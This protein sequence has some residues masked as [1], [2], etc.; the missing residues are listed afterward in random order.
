MDLYTV[1]KDFAAPFAALCGAVAAAYF[2]R[3]QSNTAKRQADIALGLAETATRQAETALDQLRFN[4][5]EKRYAVYKEARHLL[6][7]MLA[8][9]SPS[10][11]RTL[12]RRFLTAI[13]EAKFFFPPTTCHWLETVWDDCQELLEKSAASPA[14]N[15]QDL[16]ALKDKLRDHLKEMSKHFDELNFRQFTRRDRAMR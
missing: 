4:L 15:A 12:E 2:A 6:E 1:S 5:F 3:Q 11:A 13:D 10:R 7:L 14:S 8:G 9:T 16:R